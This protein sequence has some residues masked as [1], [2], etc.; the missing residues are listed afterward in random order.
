MMKGRVQGCPQY[1][2]EISENSPVPKQLLSEPSTMKAI[3]AIRVWC[4][5]YLSPW[6]GSTLKQTHRGVSAVMTTATLVEKLNSMAAE[7]SDNTSRDTGLSPDTLRFM[8]EL[9]ESTAINIISR[10]CDFLEPL[11]YPG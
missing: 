2:R 11:V 10:H 3:L 6:T 8:W 4:V 7:L 5:V 1:D 9:S